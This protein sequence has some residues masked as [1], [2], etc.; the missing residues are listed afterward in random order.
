M[1]PGRLE[2]SVGYEVSRL[3]P[4][5]AAR[6]IGKR[7]PLLLEL[8]KEFRQSGDHEAGQKLAALKLEIESI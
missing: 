8:D 5:E 1:E 6:E 4:E 7:I 3:P 2:S